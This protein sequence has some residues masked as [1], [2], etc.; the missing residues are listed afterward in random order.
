MASAATATP[1]A[2]I[3]PGATPASGRPRRW[4]TRSGRRVVEGEHRAR[5]RGRRADRGD[6]GAIGGEVGQRRLAPREPAQRWQE[7]ER[8]LRRLGREQPQRVPPARVVRLVLDDGAQ[9]ALPQRGDRAAGD[10]ELRPQQPG[11]ERERPRVA[12]DA[13][14]VTGELAPRE[15]GQLA[16]APVQSHLAPQRRA[17]APED[18]RVER[19]E[20][21][22][23]ELVAAGRGMRPG[24]QHRQVEAERVER[25]DDG[26][27]DRAGGEERQREL[28]PPY[29]VHPAAS[30]WSAA[31]RSG[32]SWFIL[33]ANWTRA[34]SPNSSTSSVT[35]AS[36][37]ACRY[38]S[39]GNT[40]W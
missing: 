15:H 32:S 18:E 33:R 13:H 39:R 19:R 9:L 22:E 35:S 23:R 12:H 11:A 6:G 26:D 17:Q 10:V 38:S 4:S 8:V 7:A 29:A 31:R 5:H 28:E 40:A 3:A 14:G 36:A 1:A 16:Q 37:R 34:S 30:R 2:A 20:Q 21:R 25:D 27:E 24:E